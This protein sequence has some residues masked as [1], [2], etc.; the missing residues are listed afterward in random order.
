MAGNPRGVRGTYIDTSECTHDDTG[1]EDEE[2][3]QDMEDDL[4]FA[5]ALLLSFEYRGASRGGQGLVGRITRLL[6]AP[7]TAAA[8]LNMVWL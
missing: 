4:P 5:R 6:L 7:V 1:A 3:E 8:V 2:A